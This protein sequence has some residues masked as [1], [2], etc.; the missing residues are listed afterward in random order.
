MAHEDFL[1]E[2]A[3]VGLAE[4]K[5]HTLVFHLGETS[6][7]TVRWSRDQLSTLGNTSFRLYSQTTCLPGGG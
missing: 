1:E 6:D 4:N 7:A 5:P 3:F 2:T